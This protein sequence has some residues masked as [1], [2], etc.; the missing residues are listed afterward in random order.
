MAP[1]GRVGSK[2]CGESPNYKFPPFLQYFLS[3]KSL[4]DELFPCRSAESTE[5][6]QASVA[7]DWRRA[8]KP[9]API[10]EQGQAGADLVTPT[11]EQTPVAGPSGPTI[12]EPPAARPT[13]PR[14]GAHN[15]GDP[16]DMPGEEAWATTG[17]L[18]GPTGAGTEIAGDT[19]SSA[20]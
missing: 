14:G 18:D 2:L 3:A 9:E 5:D 11:A 12:E 1:D 19:P 13:S 15:E 17:T 10:V 7:D 6:L 4:F 16:V 20:T 8:A